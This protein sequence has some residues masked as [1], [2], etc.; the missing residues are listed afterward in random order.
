M[1][2]N[3][4]LLII[5]LLVLGLLP[6]CNSN[7]PANTE[8]TAE[9]TFDPALGVDGLDDYDGEQLVLVD[10]RGAWKYK[11]FSM[12]YTGEDGDRVNL[13]VFDPATDTMAQYME[14]NG[15]E[16]GDKKMPDAVLEDVANW[17]T[18]RGPFG[19]HGGDYHE[20][21]IGFAGDN[22]G[23]MIFQS[24]EIVDLEEFLYSYQKL[25]LYCHYDN[26]V[27]I[28]LNGALVYRHSVD[29]SGTPDWNGSR[30]LLNTYYKDVNAYYIGDEAV[31]EMLVEGENT[32]FAMVKDAWGGRV[33]NL[34]LEC[35]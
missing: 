30:E 4:S 23:L 8:T 34:S 7:P 33:L 16:M 29:E 6:A 25:N 28:Y 24:F 21:D 22:H 35:G 31:M 15:W 3:I 1:K 13:G 27:S 14:K 9:P 20:V 10:N 26:T 17:E 19:D 32:L 12:V 18:S 11:L 5:T 2:R